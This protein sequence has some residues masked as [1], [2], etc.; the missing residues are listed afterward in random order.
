MKQLKKKKKKPAIVA[1]QAGNQNS[2]KVGKLYVIQYLSQNMKTY[3]E[4]KKKK[5]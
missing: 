3:K 1:L 5:K 4:K 2:I